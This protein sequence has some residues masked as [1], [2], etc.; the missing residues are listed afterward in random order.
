MSSATHAAQALRQLLNE[1]GVPQIN[2]TVIHG[3]N[4]PALHI[5]HNAVCSELT[6]H[7]DVRY[8]H[9]RERVERGEVAFRYVPT[10]KQV[11]D[12]FTKPMSVVK[13]I[14]FTAMLMAPTNMASSSQGEC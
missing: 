4:Q 1:L 6:R 9:I 10:D 3:D 11:A 14:E 7:I 5:A 2:A 8:H 12:M 13:H